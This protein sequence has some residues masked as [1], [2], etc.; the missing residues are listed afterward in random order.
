MELREAG[1]PDQALVDARV[2]LH[3][4]GAERVEAGVD[5]EVTVRE[6]GEVA[7]DLRLR[8]LRQTR[9]LGPREALVPRRLTA[10]P[11]RLRLLEDE[12][13][14]AATSAS[15]A[16]RRSMS[17]GERFSVTQTSSASSSPG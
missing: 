1:K 3:R 14:A 9:G 10:S 17:A 15:T 13:H 8:D 5:A 12:L 6:L 4:A 7:Q 16:A 11:S 2:V